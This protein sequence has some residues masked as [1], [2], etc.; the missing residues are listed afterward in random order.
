MRIHFVKKTFIMFMFVE[1]G[2]RTFTLYKYWKCICF[3]IWIFSQ[4]S[5]LLLRNVYILFN[6]NI[7]ISYTITNMNEF[8]IEIIYIT[9]NISCGSKKKNYLSFHCIFLFDKI[10]W[11]ILPTIS[12]M[13]IHFRCIKI[14]HRI[15]EFSQTTDI[16]IVR[17]T[18]MVFLFIHRKF[19][20]YT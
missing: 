9:Y 1:S 2:N 19:A 8:S 17:V 5:Y 11:R 6:I 14:M 20:S 18:G 10:M 15:L 12:T 3:R 4:S 13:N 16:S 7:R